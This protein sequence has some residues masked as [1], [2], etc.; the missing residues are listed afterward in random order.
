VSTKITVLV[1]M[2]R[3]RRLPLLL[4]LEEC[5]I[6]PVPADGRVEARRVLDSRYP[7]QVVL[8]DTA[9][10]DG[11]WMDVLDGVTQSG[12]KAEVVVC[13]RV[14][15]AQLWSAVLERGAYDLMIEPY[16]PEEVRRI[17][18]AAAARSYMR[19]LPPA[20]EKRT[21]AKAA[22]EAS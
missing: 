22:D 9:L 15:D 10:P 4:A 13:A 7:I 14:A 8:T 21:K 3:D 1:V 19:S 12:T 5:G 18:E 11:T 16:Q 17:I 2:A 20:K 6:D